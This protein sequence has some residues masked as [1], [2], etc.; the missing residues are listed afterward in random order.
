MFKIE[1]VD[2]GWLNTFNNNCGTKYKQGDFVSGDEKIG[3]FYIPGVASIT[4]TLKD[5]IES[6]NN[7]VAGG[8]AIWLEKVDDETKQ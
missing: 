4:Y 1:T 3:S 8:K 7:R 6:F 5:E 2:Q